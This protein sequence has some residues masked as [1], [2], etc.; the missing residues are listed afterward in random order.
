MTYSYWNRPPKTRLKDALDTARGDYDYIIIDCPPSLGLLSLNSLAA[1]DG[2]LV[3]IQCEFYALEG[4]SQIVDTIDLVHEEINPDLQIA[5]VL[6]TMFDPRTNLSAQVV[7]DVKKFFEDKVF[8]TIIPR[9]VRLSEAP[10][11]GMPVIAYDSS[12]KGAKVYMELA[13]EVLRRD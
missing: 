7:D 11:Y 3:P 6:L 9:T 5:G 1:A 13:E 2:I 10:S 4:L 8:D 12:A